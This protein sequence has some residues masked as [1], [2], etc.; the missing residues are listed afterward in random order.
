M[1]PIYFIISNASLSVID[2]WTWTY[3]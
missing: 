2:G 3:M 1:N